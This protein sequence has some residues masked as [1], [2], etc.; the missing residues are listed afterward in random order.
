MKVDNFI[1]VDTEMKKLYLCFTIFLSFCLLSLPS[2]ALEE[3]DMVPDWSL[4][5]DDGEEI[6]FYSNTGE[7]ASVLLFWATWCPYCR[8]LMPHLQELANEFQD[9]GVKFYALNVWEDGDSVGYIKKNGFTFTLLMN[10]D[11]VAGSYGVKGT[12]GLMVIDKRHILRYLRRSGQKDEEVKNAVRR[13]LES[14]ADR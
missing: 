9:K 1:R 11:P 6:S 12:P 10:A 3:K 5:T 2:F 14:L 7:T 8:A 4:Q 13:T